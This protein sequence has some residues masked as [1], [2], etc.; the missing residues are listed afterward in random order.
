MKLRSSELRWNHLEQHPLW[1]WDEENE[2]LLRPW[3]PRDGRDLPSVAAIMRAEFETAEGTLLKG[4]VSG[5]PP[6]VISFWVED[7]EFIFNR[8]LPKFVPED[9][10][11]LKV[12][13][14]DVAARVFPIRFVTRLKPLVE[15]DF[16]GVFD[17]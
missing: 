6:F 14:G 13:L 1:L 5:I 17:P 9:L 8:N 7:T 10:E 11:R 15:D 12:K 4:T 3:E 16:S 2:S